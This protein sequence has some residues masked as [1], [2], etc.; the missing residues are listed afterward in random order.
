M[1]Q[2]YISTNSQPIL[3]VDEE[4]LRDASN[5]QLDGISFFFFFISNQKSVKKHA[6]SVLVPNTLFILT[7]TFIVL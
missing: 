4:T 3:S 1:T 6:Q 7:T 2:S 5:P